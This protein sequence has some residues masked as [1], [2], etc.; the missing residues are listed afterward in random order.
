MHWLKEVLEFLMPG[1]VGSI[2]DLSVSLLQVRPTFLRANV[3]ALLTDTLGK[4]Y[5]AYQQTGFP[6]T[7][8]FNIAGR[9]FKGSPELS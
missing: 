4:G 5:L 6:Q 8:L 2:L 3:L 7:F 9:K 1:W